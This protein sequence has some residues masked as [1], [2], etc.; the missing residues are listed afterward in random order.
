MA[1]MGDTSDAKYLTPQANFTAM[2]DYNDSIETQAAQ[3][4][5]LS[6]DAYKKSA[7]YSSGYQM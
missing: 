4:A 3:Y 7:T 6:A 5:N 2:A 1:S